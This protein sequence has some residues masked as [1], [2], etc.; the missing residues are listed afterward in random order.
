MRGFA[1][2]VTD[3]GRCPY[4]DSD[5]DG[6]SYC[7]AHEGYPEARSRVIRENSGSITP[8][9]PHYEDTVEPSC[10]ST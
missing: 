9:C 8:T 4:R 2:F 10:P 3:C 5:Q 7:A 6:D 1:F